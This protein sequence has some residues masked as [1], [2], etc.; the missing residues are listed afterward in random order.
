M[1][2]APM[3]CNPLPYDLQDAL[4]LRFSGP[5][6]IAHR[7][8]GLLRRHLRHAATFPFYRQ[9]FQETGFDPETMTSCAELSRLP[10]TSRKDIDHD[11]KA[12]TAGAV[13]ATADIALTSGTTGSPLVVPFTAHD[14][15]RL[16]FNEEI[17]F[18]SAGLGEN[19]RVLLTVTLDRCFIAGFAYFRGLGRLCA[20]T[21]RSGPGQPARQ[22]QLI[23]QLRSSSPASR[24]VSGGGSSFRSRRRSPRTPGRG[25]SRRR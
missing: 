18:H 12:F 16:A 6:E 5:D 19:D 9:L 17:A 23:R 21:I 10:L 11:P 3:P 20:T 24:R 14:L 22:W 7:Q 13:P 15:E 8:T 4:R 2:T 1:S 25:G